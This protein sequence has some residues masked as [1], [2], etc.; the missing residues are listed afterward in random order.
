MNYVLLDV[1]EAR[2]PMNFLSM[3][4]AAMRNS[5]LRCVSLNT[6]DVRSKGSRNYN[7]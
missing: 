5:T 6:S 7:A 2:N 1:R 3:L 4:F